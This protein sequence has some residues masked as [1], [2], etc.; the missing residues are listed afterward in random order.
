MHIDF[1]VYQDCKEWKERGMDMNDVYPV[2][3]DAGSGESFQ[4]CY[5]A[6]LY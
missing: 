3:P 4:V 5:C 1:V 6:M 2:N